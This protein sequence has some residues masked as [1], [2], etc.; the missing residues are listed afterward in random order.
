[1]FINLEKE[2]KK[3]TDFKSIRIMLA[4]PERIR[5]WSFGEVT[6]PETINYRSFKP[7]KDGLFCERIFGPERDWEC[8]CVRDSSWVRPAS[9]AAPSLR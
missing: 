6:K 2:R 8:S 7:E 5:E 1:M 3:P 9:S 4:S